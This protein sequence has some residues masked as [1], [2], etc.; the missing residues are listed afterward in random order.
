M[1]KNLNQTMSDLDIIKLLEFA[2]SE[3][4]STSLITLYLPSNSNL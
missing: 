3:I 4:N 2:E 1:N